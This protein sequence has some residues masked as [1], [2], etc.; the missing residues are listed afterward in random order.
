MVGWFVVWRGREGERER[1]LYL[2]KEW[3]FYVEILELY[4]DFRV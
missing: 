2:G 3:E 4:V 1:I